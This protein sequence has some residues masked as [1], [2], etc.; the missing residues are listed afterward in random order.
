[1]TFQNGTIS[2]NQSGTTTQF[3]G[4]ASFRLSNRI[5][6]D[7]V[8][9]FDAPG[10]FHGYGKTE[11]CKQSLFGKYIYLTSA[12][13]IIATLPVLLTMFPFIHVFILGMQV[14]FCSG[15]G[16]PFSSRTA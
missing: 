2:I 9:R 4:I 8:F 11:C 13:L 3:P 6:R 15:R 16:K 10:R 1:M 5:N 7:E 14:T 12:V